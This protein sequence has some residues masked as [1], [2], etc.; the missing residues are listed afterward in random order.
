MTKGL[1]T[2]EDLT[3]LEAEIKALIWDCNFYK[4]RKIISKVP[5][6]HSKILDSWRGVIAPPIAIPSGTKPGGRDIR[7]DSFW[8]EYHSKEYGGQWVALKDGEFL[9]ANSNKKALQSALKQ[10]GRLEGAFLTK[11]KKMPR[12]EIQKRISYILQESGTKRKDLTPECLKRLEEKVAKGLTPYVVTM[13]TYL[14]P[15]HEFIY[16]F[17]KPE[18]EV[19]ENHEEWYEPEDIERVPTILPLWGVHVWAEEGEDAIELAQKLVKNY[20]EGIGISTTEQPGPH[21][22]QVRKEDREKKH[23]K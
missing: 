8:L 5:F 22:S 19:F 16:P 11:I 14:E 23:K 4:A 20:L 15:A 2:K 12:R 3:P 1:D 13:P 17:D 18:H 10:A 9:G 21:L 7:L 6:G